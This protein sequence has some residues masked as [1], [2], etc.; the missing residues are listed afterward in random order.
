MFHV[1]HLGPV[2]RLAFDRPDRRNALTPASLAAL[3]TE[4]RA[5]TEAGA[6]AIVLAGE[7]R[8]FC[9]GFDLT[10]CKDDPNAMRELLIGLSRAIV[11]LR[12][13][14]TPVVAAVQGAAIAGGAALLGGAD[15]VVADR[16]AMIGY[17]VVK[18]GV[19]PAVSAP[20]MR[21][22][23][24][25]GPTRAR[26]LDTELITGQRAYELGLVHELVDS[27]DDVAPRAL[28]LAQELAAKPPGA[29]AATKSWCNELGDT[30]PAQRA[31]EV[32]L[33]LTGGDEERELLEKI[34]AS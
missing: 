30:S 26:L 8:S 12:T 23:I 34:W 18:I 10:L 2:A 27:R 25:D 7:G 32:S 3:A 9:A 20:F 11:T 6:R 13:L 22:S 28:E 29:L 16:D 14:S 24:G 17:P 5:A 31:L 19:S 33:S 1:E 4:A 21:H 15:V